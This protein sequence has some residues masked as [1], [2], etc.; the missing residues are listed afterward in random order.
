MDINATRPICPECGEPL[1]LEVKTEG[2][3]HRKINKNGNLHKTVNW[4]VGSPCGPSYLVCSSYDC[5]FAYH[6]ENP[7]QETLPELDD[8]LASH[9]NRDD[10]WL[11]RMI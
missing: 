4:S 5:S 6:P 8:W 7:E 9:K 2:N 1:E 11:K 10:F 3:W